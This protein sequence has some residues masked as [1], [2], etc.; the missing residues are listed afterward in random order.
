MFLYHFS[1]CNLS[2]GPGPTDRFSVSYYHLLPI[3]DIHT[4]LRVV[5]S[6][7]LEIVIDIRLSANTDGINARRTIKTFLYIR[8]HQKI[9]V[10]RLPRL[11]LQRRNGKMRHR[12]NFIRESETSLTAPIILKIYGFF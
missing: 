8:N 3:S 12:R 11:S 7:P 5:H 10:E 9:T 1:S 2:L 6:L 4:L